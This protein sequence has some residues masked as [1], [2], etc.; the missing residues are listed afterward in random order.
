MIERLLQIRSKPVR[1]MIG[2]MSGTSLDGV[3]A[4][5]V[6]ISGFAL[7]TRIRLIDFI[8]IPY[9]QPV[10]KRLLDLIEGKPVQR[11]SAANFLLGRKFAD[12]AQQVMER[13]GLKAGEIDLIGSHGHTVWHQH[14]QHSLQFAEPSVIAERTGAV[15]IADFRVRDIAAGGSGAPLVPYVDFLLCRSDTYGRILQNVGGIANCTLL[16]RG[17]DQVDHLIAFDTGPGVMICDALVKAFTNGTLTYDRD[18][19]IARS[20]TI[21]PEWLEVWKRDPY[22]EKPP[23]KSCGREQFGSHFAN[24]LLANYPLNAD[25]IATVTA[26]TAHTIADA[27]QRFL[28]P[29]A[30]VDQIILSGGGSKNPFLVNQLQ[31]LLPSYHILS[32]DEVGL[33]SDAKEAMAFAI[34][35]NETL[36]GQ[37][38]NVPAVTGARHPVVL[39]K[40]V[41]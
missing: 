9:P 7:D 39:G 3:D 21:H 40:I 1:L 16:P 20:G 22:F 2:L 10:R 6:E 11:A 13:H 23:P 26:F 25:L 17:I 18:G 29:H 24:N 30:P 12:A 32:S 5:L 27:Y 33:P 31:Q 36:F 4:A 41:L 15:V 38:A 37:P 8:T 14:R 34:L 19:E 28:L 35:A